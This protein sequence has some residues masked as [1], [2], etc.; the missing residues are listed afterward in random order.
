MSD[1]QWIG[2]NAI[3][4]KGRVCPITENDGWGV[5]NAMERVD[6]EEREKEDRIRAEIKTEIISELKGENK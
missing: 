6:R 3:L 4:Y 5:V 2:N 1:F